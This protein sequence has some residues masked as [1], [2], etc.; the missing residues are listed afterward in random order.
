LTCGRPGD[1]PQRPL[2]RVAGGKAP[3][4]RETSRTRGSEGQG[5]PSDLVKTIAESFV[6][7]QLEKDKTLSESWANEAKRL[8]EKE[9]I[10]VL[11]AQRLGTLTKPDIHKMLAGI[12]KRGSPIVANRVLAVF[13]RLSNWSVFS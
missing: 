5:T 2:A 12:V 8:L 9:V 1:R 4:R 3:A 13:R 7:L 11:G 6:K 10:P